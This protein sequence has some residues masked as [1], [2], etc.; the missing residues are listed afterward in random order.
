MAAQSSGSLRPSD[1]E[2]HT[3]TRKQTHLD[4][5]QMHAHARKSAQIH[6][7]TRSSM[8]LVWCVVRG[9]AFVLCICG[10]QGFRRFS[11]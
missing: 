7:H 2:V 11:V 9:G 4:R 6:T 3:H 5:R 8:T 1:T 10:V